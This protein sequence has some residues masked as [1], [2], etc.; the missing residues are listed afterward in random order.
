MNCKIMIPKFL[1]RNK[2]TIL[3]GVSL[4]LL[5]FQRIDIKTKIKLACQL[6]AIS[7]EDLLRHL[8]YLF[9]STLSRKS[10]IY[11]TVGSNQGSKRQK[12]CGASGKLR[13]SE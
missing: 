9:F 7:Q 5:L 1:A 6:S 3:Y 12:E 13:T 8:P 10:P 4:A 2:H 11:L